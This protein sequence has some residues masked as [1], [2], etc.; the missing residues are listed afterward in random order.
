MLINI[1]KKNVFIN[2]MQ[3][4]NIINSIILQKYKLFEIFDI[5]FDIINFFNKI[6]DIFQ[7]YIYFDKLN[8]FII[9][10]LNYNLTYNVDFYMY[11]YIYLKKI[12]RK[13]FK[14]YINTKQYKD[15]I[16]KN[17]LINNVY[18][19]IIYIYIYYVFIYLFLKIHLYIKKTFL[20]KISKY[21]K[22]KKLSF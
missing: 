11:Y 6:V 13:Y 8:K 21:F 9:K 4:A 5:L 2:V 20:S 14:L 22:R 1:L 12:R 18:Q 15:L 10:Y 17:K 16:N 19:H 3:F 7:S